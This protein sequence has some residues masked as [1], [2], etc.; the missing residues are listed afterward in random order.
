MIT[1]ITARIITRRRAARYK[2]K[3]APL[4]PLLP[5]LTGEQ[6]EAEAAPVAMASD[7]NRRDDRSVRALLAN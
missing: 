1:T 3:V 2:L 7:R 6:V 4:C 5:S